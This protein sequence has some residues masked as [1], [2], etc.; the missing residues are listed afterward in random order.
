MS[1]NGDTSAHGDG[2]NAFLG[3]GVTSS[4]AGGYD[5]VV[6]GSGDGGTGGSG[7]VGAGELIGR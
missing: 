4:G 6:V 1:L 5:M 2:G 3:T 7:L